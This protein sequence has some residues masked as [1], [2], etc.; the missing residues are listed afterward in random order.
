MHW[1]WGGNSDGWYSGNILTPTAMNDITFYKI[2]CYA[3][4]TEQIN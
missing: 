4:T 3:I 1:G 2:K